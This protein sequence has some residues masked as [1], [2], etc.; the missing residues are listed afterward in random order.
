[1]SLDNADA[2]ATVRLSIRSNPAVSVE[3]PRQ[4]LAIC[5]YITSSWEQG[6][7]LLT[8]FLSASRGRSWRE[9][10]LFAWAIFLRG[11][12]DIS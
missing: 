2:K 4:N 5:N 12:H 9:G 10:G 3:V 11:A 6:A 8:C 1:M 7:F